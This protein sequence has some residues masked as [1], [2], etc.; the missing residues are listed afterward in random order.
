MEDRPA[1]NVRIGSLRGFLPLSN[2][3]VSTR[4]QKLPS[5]IHRRSTVNF[6]DLR[7]QLEQR[8]FSIHNERAGQE[9]SDDGAGDLEA[10]DTRRVGRLRAGE[11]AGGDTKNMSNDSNILMTPQMRSMRLIGNNN[12]RYQWYDRRSVNM[13]SGPYLMRMI[14]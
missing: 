2:D 1:P 3:I 14:V 9:N 7:S 11:E 13:S 6:H 4:G 10:G 12:P 5:L 8:R